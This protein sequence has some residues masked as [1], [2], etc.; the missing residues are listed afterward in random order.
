MAATH[1]IGIGADTEETKD[2]DPRQPG[3][4]VERP[5]HVPAAPSRHLDAEGIQRM[6]EAGR[7]ELA[8]QIEHLATRL[9]GV[10]QTFPQINQ[11]F[12]TLAARIDAV[13]GQMAERQTRATALDMA[14]KAA[15]PLEPSTGIVAAAEEFL[16]FLDPKPPQTIEPVAQQQEED[17]LDHPEPPTAH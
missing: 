4:E 17:G 12:T 13:R 11:S 15:Q 10:E 2:A 7:A 5:E 14:I 3:P 8:A 1:G 9:S 6:F 16:K